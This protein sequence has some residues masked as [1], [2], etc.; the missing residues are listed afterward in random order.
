MATTGEAH[1]SCRFRRETPSQGIRSFSSAPIVQRHDAVTLK[2]VEGMAILIHGQINRSRTLENG[3]YQEGSRILI[4]PLQQ[5]M[6]KISCYR[7]WWLKISR[8]MVA[9]GLTGYIV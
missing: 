3:F 9:G 1:R 6:A 4:V 7:W 8:K 2:T 5:C